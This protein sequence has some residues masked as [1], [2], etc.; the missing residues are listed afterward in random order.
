MQTKKAFIV[1]DETDTCFLLKGIL[2]Q[3]G[4]DAEFVHSLGDAKLALETRTADVIFLDNH[5]KDG[6]GIEFIPHLTANYP[7]LKIIIITAFDT[8]HDKQHAYVMGA[9]HFM[10]KPFN[11]QIISEALSVVFPV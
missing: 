3:Q 1:D 8:D 9:H 10:G 6:H 7:S 5:L 2:T 11:R 4:F